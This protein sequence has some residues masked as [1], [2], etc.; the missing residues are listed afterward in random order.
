MK[1]LES[2]SLGD[3]WSIE[4]VT[5]SLLLKAKYRYDNRQIYQIAL[6]IYMSPIPLIPSF[7]PSSVLIISP[8]TNSQSA[9]SSILITKNYSRL[10]TIVS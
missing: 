2:F 10:E 1:D 9:A 6:H 5:V 8:R 4:M 7:L 3:S